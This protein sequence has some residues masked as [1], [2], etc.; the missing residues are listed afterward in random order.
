MEELVGK[1]AVPKDT[2]PK[3][4]LRHAGELAKGRMCEAACHRQLHEIYMYTFF[5]GVRKNAVCHIRV[6]DVQGFVVGVVCIGDMKLGCR[7]SEDEYFRF[8]LSSPL[9]FV[10]VPEGE[11][12][13]HTSIAGAFF[14]GD[15]EGILM[16]LP[17]ACSVGL[18][19]LAAEY[20]A[21]S[22]VS[23]VY[24]GLVRYS[25]QTWKANKL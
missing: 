25:N 23:S 14:L 1:N 7:L 5:R 19:F 13:K 9:P 24:V 10:F 20:L 17:F 2:F 16:D 4:I 21:R 18:D 8:L 12:K 11:L 6:G 15:D 22:D 3:L